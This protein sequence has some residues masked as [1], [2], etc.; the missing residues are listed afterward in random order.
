MLKNKIFFINFNNSNHIIINFLGIKI[1]LKK[2]TK[3]NNF[4]EIKKELFYI[5][6]SLLYEKFKKHNIENAKVIVCSDK[7]NNLEFIYPENFYY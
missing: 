6:K 4:E 3:E 5:K 7:C 1:K 2:K